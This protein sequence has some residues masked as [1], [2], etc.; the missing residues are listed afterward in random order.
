MYQTTYHRPSSV[1]EAV[2]LF[3]KGSDSK[4]LAGSASSRPATES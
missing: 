1:D 3:A 2:S 4:Y